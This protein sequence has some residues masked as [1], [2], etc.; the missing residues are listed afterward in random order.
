MGCN[1]DGTTL[2]HPGAEDDS[3]E[4]RVSYNVLI[5]KNAILFS[6]E[7]TTNLHGTG[8]LSCDDLDHGSSSSGHR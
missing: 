7:T 6:N 2:P 3:Y 8:S 1:N 5:R 4:I